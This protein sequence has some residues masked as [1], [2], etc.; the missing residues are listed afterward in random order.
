MDY[1][2]IL[3]GLESAYDAATSKETIAALLGAGIAGWFGFKA[4]ERAHA[5]ALAKAEA[6][7]KRITRQTLELLMVEVSTAL[8]VFDHEYAKDLEALPEGESYVCQFP[9]GENTFPIYD[10]APTC[11]ANLPPEISSTLVRLYMRMKGMIA[12]IK[13]NNEDTAQAHAAARVELLKVGTLSFI[14]PDKMYEKMVMAAADNLLMGSTADA[15]KGLAVEIRD[16]H[17]QL[18]AQV[19]GQPCLIQ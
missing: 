4:T 14:D 9:I 16:L 11:L 10:S 18:L 19:Y 3:R 13:A 5:F 15:M 2:T 8:A 12:M 17:K 6:D 7:D 1:E